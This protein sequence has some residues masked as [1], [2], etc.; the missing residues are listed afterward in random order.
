[1]ATERL[2][3]AAVRTLVPDDY[4]AHWQKTLAFLDILIER[5]P[6]VLRQE[7]AVDAAEPRNRVLAAQAALGRAAPPDDPLSAA[8]P[9]DRIPAP[10]DLLAV[11]ATV[12]R[13]AIVL[14]GLDRA[15]SDDAWDKLDAG[16]PQFGL[17]ALLE[18]LAV[19]RQAVVAWPAYGLPVTDPA[20]ARWLGC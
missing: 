19:P 3:L 20:R 2:E 12:P 7:A 17:K 1:V 15:I 16:H 4:A 5:W 10:A 13:G 11:I 9:P 14:P 8:R 6:A 18:R